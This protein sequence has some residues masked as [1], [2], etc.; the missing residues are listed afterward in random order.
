MPERVEAFSEVYEQDNLSFRELDVS[1]SDAVS[2]LFR[3]VSP[4]VVYHLAHQRCA[5]YSMLGLKEAVETIK[6]NEVGFLNIIW[7][8]KEY[9]PDCHL[10]KLGSFGAYMKSGLDITE[11]NAVLELNGKSSG[12]AVPLP[13]A[14]DDFYHITK[15]NDGN[16]AGLACRKW[17]LAITDVMQSTV[18]GVYTSRTVRD[19]RLN[20]RFDYDQI[21]GTVLN[22]FIAQVSARVPMTVYGDGQQSTGI[23][24]L[25]DCVKVLA[26]LASDPA[27]P[28][29]HRIINN[30]P[31]KY[32]INELATMTKAE[33][34]KFQLNPTI[35]VNRFNPRYEG[36]P[37]YEYN[38]QTPYIDALINPTDIRIAI[39]Q[40]IETV[41]C[42]GPEIN[43]A[44]IEPTHTW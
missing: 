4:D 19:P 42:A 21:F 6:N 25:E 22:R 7:S 35:S 37:S 5:P 11:G 30:C 10:I 13:R 36:G 29:E 34:E 2:E 14:S 15:I 39:R 9:C 31:A 17:D 23:M 26:H 8:I 32:S 28:G 41:R 33:A 12:C 16:F 1:D 43:V 44:S 40:G 20:T 27:K 24:V 3:E 38:V 18:F